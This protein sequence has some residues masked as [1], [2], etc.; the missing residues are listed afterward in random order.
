MNPI[1]HNNSTTETLPPPTTHQAHKKHT[2]GSY[3]RTY[4]HDY[5]SLAVMGILGIVIYLLRPLPNRHF[6]LTFSDGEVVYPQYAYALQKNI[7]PIWLAA[8]LAFMVGF[9]TM[10]V[11]QFWRIRNFFDFSAGV[12]GLLYS[13][14]T[15]ALFQVFLKWAIGGL[16]PHFYDVCKPNVSGMNVGT[17]YQSLMVD[18]SVCTG[19][20]KLIN[21][22]LESFPSGHS[23]AAFA[24]FVFTSLYLNAKLKIF[25]PV[26]AHYLLFVLFFAPILG[27]TL[28][29]GSLTIDEFHNWYD[30]VG[31][32]IIGT[33]MAFAGFRFV[34]SA[35]FDWRVNH[36]P[37]VRDSRYEME[38]VN[39]VAT[40]RGPWSNIGEHKVEGS[41][42]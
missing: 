6:P 41:Q 17:G 34:Y 28:I 30:C 7:V 29:A 38:G 4:W 40:R 9:V 13:L 42:E 10:V 8:F 15:A 11:L 39:A 26:R 12:L 20:E 3:I 37:L 33:V 31:G 2:P 36:I 27:A 35:I 5:V 19:D 22:A 18:R 21:D 16:R 32:A 1:Q 14:V 23:T 25:S 24:G